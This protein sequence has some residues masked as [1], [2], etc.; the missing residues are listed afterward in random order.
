M[1]GLLHWSG[2]EVD[3]IALERDRAIVSLVLAQTVERVAHA[4]ESSTVWD[5]AVRQVGRK[6]L[7]EGW[8]GL[9]LG[10]WF[11]YYAGIDEIYILD[12]H[13]RPIYAMRGGKRTAP[14]NYVALEDVAAPMASW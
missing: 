13:D 2:R 1:L 6:P 3:R 4:Q 8:L 14:E 7:D 9:N 12:P 5:E 10:E 11:E